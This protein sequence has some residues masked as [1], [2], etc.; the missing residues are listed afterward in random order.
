MLLQE[1]L[2]GQPAAG[3]PP[4]LSALLAGLLDAA[5]DAMANGPVFSHNAKFA[6]QAYS[7][8]QHHQDTQLIE[9]RYGE[10]LDLIEDWA[11]Q[12]SL[13]TT[14]QMPLPGAIGL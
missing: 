6:D 2:V 13:G 5:L 8:G 11:A 14:L 3:W 1:F 4:K 12:L 9:K 7:A 10:T